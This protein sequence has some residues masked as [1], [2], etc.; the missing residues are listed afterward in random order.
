MLGVEYFSARGLLDVPR[1]DVQ[2]AAERGLGQRALTVGMW[3]SSMPREIGGRMRSDSPGAPVGSVRP[4]GGGE[5]RMR[6]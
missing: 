4:Y 5:G 6:Q 2:E 1:R 3:E